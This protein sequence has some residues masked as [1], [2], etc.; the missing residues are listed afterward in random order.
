MHKSAATYRDAERHNAVQSRCCYC[1]TEE[2]LLGLGV[3]KDIVSQCSLTNLHPLERRLGESVY[4][5]YP[6]SSRLNDKL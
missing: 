5:R 3:I 6:L 1:E 4:D 2:G